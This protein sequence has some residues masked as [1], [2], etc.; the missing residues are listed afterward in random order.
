MFS[1]PLWLLQP[2]GVVKVKLYKGNVTI[3]GRKSPYS[4]YDKVRRYMLQARS[5]QSAQESCPLRYR[6]S[7]PLYVAVISI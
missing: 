5:G 2:A 4:L 1:A 3:C 7:L 6:C